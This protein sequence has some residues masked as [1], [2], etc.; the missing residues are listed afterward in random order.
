MH[1]AGNFNAHTPFLGYEDWNSRGREVETLCLS[2][3]LVLQQDMDSEPTLL[4][5]RN[6]TTSR[7]DLTIVSADIIVRTTTRVLVDIGSDHKPTL[8][9]ISNLEQDEI[10]RKIFLEF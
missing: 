10:K 4:H 9:T 3:N 2:S 7:P 5:K 8:I 1:I 6:N